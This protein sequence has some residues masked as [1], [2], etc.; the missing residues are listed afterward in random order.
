MRQ[1]EKVRTV[2][3]SPDAWTTHVTLVNVPCCRLSYIP[4]VFKHCDLLVLK[5]VILWEAVC[6]TLYSQNPNTAFKIRFWVFTHGL[7]RAGSF[8]HWVIPCKLTK[9]GWKYPLKHQEVA[10]GTPLKESKLG[11]LPCSRTLALQSGL[12]HWVTI[13][14]VLNG[15]KIDNESCQIVIF[16]CSSSKHYRRWNQTLKKVF[17]AVFLNTS[18]RLKLKANSNSIRLPPPIYKDFQVL[19]LVPTDFQR[20]SR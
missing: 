11:A 7:W 10:E 3:P 14:T 15:T 20:L 2:S 8:E 6:I 9:R 17:N 1:P 18:K 16:K 13:L 4:Y 5:I 19:C 12:Q